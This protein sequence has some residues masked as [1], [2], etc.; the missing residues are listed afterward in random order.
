MHR[1]NYLVPT[2]L[3]LVFI[4]CLLYNLFAFPFSREARLM[5]YFVQQIDLNTG[6]NNVTVNGLD[7]YVRTIIEELPSSSGQALNCGS[8]VSDNFREGLTTC[9]WHG[10]APNVLANSDTSDVANSSSD[11]HDYDSW[12]YYNITMNDTHAAFSFQGRNT[13]SCRLVFDNPV[14]TVDIE[15]AASDPRYISVADGGSSE[16][17]LFSRNWDEVFKVNVTWSDQE[18][19][20][21]TGKVMC[22]WSDANQLGVIPAFDELRRFQ[23][24]WSAATKGGDGLVEGWK[25]FEL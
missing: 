19:H 8:Q 22:L 15:D 7:K 21:Q 13:K 5:V 23:P 12:L 4:G 25:A 16:V 24:V 10:L 17:R 6:N 11:I 14:A 2:L 3:F 9:V 1:F 18:T 20:G